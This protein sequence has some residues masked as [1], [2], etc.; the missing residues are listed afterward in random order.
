[1]TLFIGVVITIVGLAWVIGPVLMP[2]MMRQSHDLEFERLGSLYQ[3]LRHLHKDKVKLAEDDFKNIER[4]LMLDIARNYEKMGVDPQGDQPCLGCG[5]PIRPSDKFCDS[6]GQT[7]AP[8]AAAGVNCPACEEPLSD[9]YKF[10][11][12]CG[13][14]VEA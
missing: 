13:N 6:C 10:C 12:H 11:P 14:K 5:N 2:T 3:S 7:S 1:M 4:R 8:R 9:L